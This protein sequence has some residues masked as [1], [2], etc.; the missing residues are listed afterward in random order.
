MQFTEAVSRNGNLKLLVFG[1]GCA[2]AALGFSSIFWY[3]IKLY[4]PIGIIIAA[5]A[6]TAVVVVKKPDLVELCR[7]R[8]LCSYKNAVG[9]N[10]GPNS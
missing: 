10:N 1:M 9:K 5:M 6:T 4:R 7:I 8:V 2:I 3:S